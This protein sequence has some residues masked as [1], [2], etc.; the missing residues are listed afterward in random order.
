MSISIHAWGGRFFW[1]VNRFLAVVCSLIVLI[2]IFGSISFTHFSEYAPYASEHTVQERWFRNG[3]FQFFHDLPVASWFFIGVEALNLACKEVENP[4]RDIPRGYMA[5]ITTLVLTAVGILFV[6][7]SLS[8][9][10]SVMLSALTPLDSGFQ[11]M[12]G[13]SKEAATVFS[14]PATFATGFGFMF[15]YG[16]QLKAMAGSGLVNPLIG[17]VL[18]G[19][20]TPIVALAVGSLVGYA[21]CLLVFYVPVVGIE[22][23]NICLLNAYTVY[24]SQFVSFVLFRSMYRSIKR[25]F[26][27]PLGIPGA[28]YGFVIFAIAFGSCSSLQPTCV[29]I[30]AYGSYILVASL[31][32]YL[33]VQKRQYF[34][35]EEKTVLFRAHLMKSKL[36][37]NSF[38]NM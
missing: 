15:C 11:L 18:P 5:S 6:C 12:F 37:F 19:R 25:E 26:T 13:I 36:D 29:A 9:G 4:K 27:N 38:M 10:V 1:S 23:F 28:V 20:D 22:L 32:Y 16:R 3:A 35:E 24:F 7:C 31:Y 17:T 21:V 8:P 2:Y 30:I 14:L 34:S 33:V